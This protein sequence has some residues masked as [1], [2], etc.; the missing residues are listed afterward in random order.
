MEAGIN[1]NYDRYC[2]SCGE[3][4][5]DIIVQFG[6]CSAC[7]AEHLPNVKIC[8]GCE[9]PFSS[10][11]SGEH[12]WRCKWEDYLRS[13]A[14]RIEEL[15]A[16]GYKMVQIRTI[17]RDERKRHCAVCGKDIVGGTPNGNSY[18]FCNDHALVGKAYKHRISKGMEPDAALSEALKRTKKKYANTA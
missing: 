6:W 17:I 5:K 1:F 10:S 14:D 11:S 2:P 16:A 3:W 7:V 18:Y 15:L 12:C 4:D 8:T 9:E 13:N